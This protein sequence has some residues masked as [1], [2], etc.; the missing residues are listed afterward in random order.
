M[1]TPAALPEAPPLPPGRVVNVP[2]RGELFVR[3]DLQ[4]SGPAVVLIHGWTAD[5]D[6]N[7]HAVF[8]FL[9]GFRVIAPDLRGHGRSFFPEAAF[10]IADAAED[11]AALLDHLGISSAIVVGYS[12]GGAVAQELAGRRPDLVTGL[13]LAATELHPRRRAGRGA[14]VR[15]EG[16]GLSLRRLSRGRWLSHRLVSRAAR[17]NPTIEPLRPWLVSAF[18]RG[19]P[20][21]LREAGRAMA[22]FDGTAIA[23]RRV[24]T[25]P[26]AVVVTEGDL[27]IRPANQQDLARAWNAATFGVAADHDAPIAA[28]AELGRAIAEA[29]AH[30]AVVGAE[31]G[32]AA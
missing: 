8:P 31:P 15:L 14:M 9:D 27:L 11:V 21:S 22:R 17:A 29:V 26:V 4:A 16:F 23:A 25:M 12:L 3:G 32:R 5:A 10:T 24:G 2:G 28:P 6:V 20:A 13:V 7:F 1:P 18:E 30:V 19:H